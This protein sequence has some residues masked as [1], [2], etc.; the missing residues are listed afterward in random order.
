M[1][2]LVC[3]NYRFFP[4]VRLAWELVHDGQVGELYQAR[5]RYSQQWRTDPS[6][7]LPS[8]TGVLGIIGC[9]AVDQARFLCGEIT[10][11]QAAISSRVTTP[12]RL[13]Q[14]HPVD[15]D[16]TVAIVARM[17]NGLV[18]TID[19]SLVSPGS[20]QLPGLGTERLQGQSCLEPG[21]AQRAEDLPRTWA[22][23]PVSPK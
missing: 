16:D 23:L 6:A 2:H 13:Y 10:S 22:G 17:E 18:A 12:A 4:A 1:R 3:F 19:A 21:G 14:G 8:S 15:Q 9:H 20:A 7:S 5:S 11:V